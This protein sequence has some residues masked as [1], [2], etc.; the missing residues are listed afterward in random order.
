MDE[1]CCVNR[2][3]CSENLLDRLEHLLLSQVGYLFAAT[4]LHQSLEAA[5]L[6]QCCH[7]VL[8]ALILVDHLHEIG[9]PGPLAP[10]RL[11]SL[12]ELDFIVRR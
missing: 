3:K 9:Q 4:S 11:E 7:Q 12:A 5:M 1:A 2:V 6:H 8:K 10:Q